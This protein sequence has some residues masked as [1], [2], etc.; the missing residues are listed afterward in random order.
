MLDGCGLA[1]ATFLPIFAQ[2]SHVVNPPLEQFSKNVPIRMAANSF[3][4]SLFGTPSS[5]CDKARDFLTTAGLSY[6]VTPIEPASATGG[7]V[8]HI[9]TR[10]LEGFDAA[11]YRGALEEAGYPSTADTAQI[12][13][14]LMYGLLALLMIWDA[15]A[16][17]PMSAYHVELFPAKIRYTSISVPYNIGAAFGGLAPFMSTAL[18]AKTG[19]V[20]SGLWYAIIVGGISVVIGAVFM[21]ETKAVYVN[22]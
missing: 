21:R 12:N 19:N 11:A 5:D 6:Q 22:E 2:L 14:P 15:M 3:G 9:G 20:Y 18:A 7:L 1:V 17:G 8:T 16:Y 4:L 10:R 13:R